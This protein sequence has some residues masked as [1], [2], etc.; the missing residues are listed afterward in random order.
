MNFL[1]GWRR[2]IRSF[3]QEYLCENENNGLG[4]NSNSARRF[5]YPCRYSSANA[6][7]SLNV[8]F[9]ENSPKRF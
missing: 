1:A 2:Y 5:Y 8:K 3:S 6:I 9:H 4:G 7:V